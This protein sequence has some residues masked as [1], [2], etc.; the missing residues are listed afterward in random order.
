[1]EEQTRGFLFPF[2]PVKKEKYVAPL[3]GA[4]QSILLYLAGRQ[5]STKAG[6]V[7]FLRK[8]SYHWICIYWNVGENYIKE[9]R[10]TWPSWN[11]KE[12]SCYSEQALF[13]WLQMNPGC[14]VEFNDR[15]C[16]KVAPSLTG[17][18]AS[19][20]CIIFKNLFFKKA[21]EF[22]ST[23]EKQTWGS[24]MK[25]IPIGICWAVKYANYSILLAVI[26]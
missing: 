21:H 11:W 15:V 19:E 8:L 22:T 24:L 23:E 1:M 18:K 16:T 7:V 13:W 12:K 3:D 10:E 9:F 20:L 17:S 26:Y 6:P 4:A 5:P 2:L 25:D 14:C